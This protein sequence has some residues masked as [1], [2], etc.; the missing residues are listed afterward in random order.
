MQMV[1]KKQKIAFYILTT[2]LVGGGVAFARYSPRM[3]AVA[4]KAQPLNN[5]EITC[6][7]YDLT[8]EN[9]REMRNQCMSQCKPK[10]KET[11]DNSKKE[12]KDALAK[13]GINNSNADANAKKYEAAARAEQKGKMSNGSKVSS[14]GKDAMLTQAGLLSGLGGKLHSCSQEIDQACSDAI[15]KG[16]DKSS[17]KKASDACDQAAA[18]ADKGAAEANNDA[19]QMDKDQKTGEKNAEGMKPPE[20]PKMP[21]MPKSEQPQNAQNDSGVTNPELKTSSLTGGNNAPGSQVAID[22]QSAMKKADDPSAVPV[23]ASGYSSV[24]GYEYPNSGGYGS[25]GAGEQANNST[26]SSS[27]GLGSGFGSGGGASEGA[28][29]PNPTSIAALMAAKD[30]EANAEFTGGGSRPS[31]I[32]MKSKGSELA[33]LGIDTGASS[34]AADAT[35]EKSNRGPASVAE[36]GEGIHHAD[37]DTLFNMIHVKL[38]DIG[39]R[40]SI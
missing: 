9:E 15:L 22:S 12:V 1:S 8:K 39:R 27:A 2:L 24:S 35:D 21:E 13:D 11:V 7:G 18:A 40:G 33:D 10:F 28:P 29:A 3:T 32:G 38:S 30:A 23:G 25:T 34:N 5:V 6:Q 16:Q 14:A 4:Q 36:Q 37:S 20:M 31:F 17:K 19:N 26:G